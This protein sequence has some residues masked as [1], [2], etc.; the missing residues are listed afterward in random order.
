MWFVLEHSCVGTR[1]F[2]FESKEAAEKWIADQG[3]WGLQ[4]ELGVSTS[5]IESPRKAT[6]T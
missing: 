3:D 1:K 5:E 4:Y 6:Y 2:I